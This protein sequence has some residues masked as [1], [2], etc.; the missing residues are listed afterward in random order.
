MS[1]LGVGTR[2]I[3]L[4]QRRSV[5]KRPRDGRLWLCCRLSY[6]AEDDVAPVQVRGVLR[7]DEELGPVGVGA[8]VGHRE[9]PRLGVLQLEVLVLEPLPVDGLS[10]VFAR[11]NMNLKSASRPASL[12]TLYPSLTPSI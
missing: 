12:P 5:F 3:L 9:E 8:G 11:M 2:G 10:R 7:G 6:L 4:W 1:V